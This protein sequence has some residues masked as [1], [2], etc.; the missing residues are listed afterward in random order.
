MFLLSLGPCRVPAIC[1]RIFISIANANENY[2]WHKRECRC[3][4]IIIYSWTSNCAV[5]TDVNRN[6]T[7]E[8]FPA[9]WWLF[10]FAIL[11]TSFIIININNLRL[12]RDS[13]IGWSIGMNEPS[14]HI[15]WNILRH[16]VNTLS[17]VVF[18]WSKFILLL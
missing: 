14:A 9:L 1:H 13:D 16:A 15:L 8:I 4:V 3:L 10:S 18:W 17:P 2:F 11:A 5:F 7:V 6:H 12:F